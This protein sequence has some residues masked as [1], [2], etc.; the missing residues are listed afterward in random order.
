[1][2]QDSNQLTGW[3]HITNVCVFIPIFRPDIE[4]NVHKNK[5]GSASVQYTLGF[6]WLL[7]SSVD[8]HIFDFAFESP[9]KTCSHNI[10]SNSHWR[11]SKD[12]LLT[13]YLILLSCN[14]VWFKEKLIE[15]RKPAGEY[16]G[17]ESRVL[18]KLPQ[19]HILTH[20]VFT[21]KQLISHNICRY[22]DNR[23]MI[24]GKINSFLTCLLECVADVEAAAKPSLKGEVKE[25]IAWGIV[26]LPSRGQGVR[27]GQWRG[28][29]KDFTTK[30]RGEGGSVFAF[31]RVG[32]R[33][34]ALTGNTRAGKKKWVALYWGLWGAKGNLEWKVDG[35]WGI[36]LRSYSLFVL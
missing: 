22:G 34:H 19:S 3:Y 17:I 35:C 5:I 11:N 25:P 29:V 36:A 2:N 4:F 16:I 10:E 9:T 13:F 7:W 23:Q 8:L 14:K 30:K 33:T 31:P 27:S 20:I 26:S 21:V 1:M 6:L 32:E 15:K 18:C 28:S 24:A 12:D